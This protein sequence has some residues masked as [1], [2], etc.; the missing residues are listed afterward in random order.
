MV[1]MYLTSSFQSTQS[2][3]PVP[4]NM[5]TAI[6][7][8]LTAQGFP[9]TF[10]NSLHTYIKAIQSD[11]QLILLANVTCQR[12]QD[13]RKQERIN[14]AIAGVSELASASDWWLQEVPEKVILE[15]LA[16]Y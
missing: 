10:T 15:C 13:N 16:A 7:T 4:T 8:I 3:P 14:Q 5:T 1:E 9:S 2:L 12:R 11:P 6:L